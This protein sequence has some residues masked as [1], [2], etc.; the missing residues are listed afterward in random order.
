M[1]PGDEADQDPL[2]KRVLGDPAGAASVL[3]ERIYATLTGLST[4]LILLGH[5]EDTSAGSAATSVAV[6]MG[7]LF[8]AAL[9]ADLVAHSA[10]RGDAPNRSQWRQIGSVAGQAVETAVVPVVVI[11]L[12]GTGIWTV[13]TGLII[14]ASVLVL[15]LALI[16]VWAVRRTSFGIGKRIAIIAGELLLGAL[17]VGIKLLAH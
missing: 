15:T 17:V 9:V 3:R 7:G 13:R 10:I 1:R 8:A 11:A 2:A 5:A 14:A 12:A 6:T 4:V 16:A